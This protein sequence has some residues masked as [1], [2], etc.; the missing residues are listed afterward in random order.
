M[1]GFTENC[2]ELAV[3][4]RRGEFLEWLRNN[5]LPTID[6]AAWSWVGLLNK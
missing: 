3:S 2:M 5:L 1:A 4:I 6:S